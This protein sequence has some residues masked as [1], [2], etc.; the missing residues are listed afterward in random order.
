MLS[1]PPLTSTQKSELFVEQPLNEKD[2]NLQE[3]ILYN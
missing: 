1:S 3:M 2:Q